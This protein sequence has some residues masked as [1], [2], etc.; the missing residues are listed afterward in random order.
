MRDNKQVVKANEFVLAIE[1][2]SM[3]AI[4][5][6]VVQRCITKLDISDISKPVTFTPK[7]VLG[8]HLTQS[9]K[10]AII[11]ACEVLL[12]TTIRE[13]N[14]D[15]TAF[16][17]LFKEIKWMKESKE[18]RFLF[19]DAN[20]HLLPKLKNRYTRYNYDNIVTLK[21]S[22][23]IRIYEFACMGID[24]YSYNE[25]SVVD[26]LS[27]LSV[28][29]NSSYHKNFN[30]VKSNILDIA[31]NEITDKTDISASWK[32]SKTKGKKVTHIK[33]FW[34]YKQKPDAISENVKQYPTDVLMLVN[35]L[36]ITNLSHDMIKSLVKAQYN[37]DLQDSDIAEIQNRSNTPTQPPASPSKGKVTTQTTPK[38]TQP[39]KTTVEDKTERL[40]LRLAELE[41][42]EWQI[43][44]VIKELEVETNGTGKKV[45]GYTIWSLITEV[46]QA[47]KD[48]IIKTSLGGYFVKQIQ[49]KFA[50]S[51]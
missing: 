36:L 32:V 27:I 14:T 24:A 17:P 50:I 38:A 6:K 19:N 25:F 48:G 13:F 47:K 41:L 22:F 9:S 31:C 2:P 29:E 44:K 37:Y 28:D 20:E 23:S 12:G 7:D 4:Q 11:R 26:L 18:I 51:F 43:E 46:K 33:I 10:R 35:Q 42:S 16:R 21:S 1:K 39:K 3:T 15:S 49:A 8:E 30:L 40:K 34:S 45:N 5:R